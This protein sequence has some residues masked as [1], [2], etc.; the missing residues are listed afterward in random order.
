MT[1]S[2]VTG[3]V[4]VWLEAARTMAV[5]AGKILMNWF[6]GPCRAERKGVV[7]LV[8]EADRASESHILGAI[9]ERFPEHSVLAEE[10]AG[11][12]WRVLADE[13]I[14]AEAPLWIVDPLDGTTNFAHGFP[15]FC[16]SI[17]VSVKG[18]VVAGV[19]HD[20]LR[21][22]T[23]EA[24]K[25]GGA[26]LNGARVSV[27]SV[28][29]LDESLLVTG[30]AYDIRT[31]PD[32]NLDIFARFAL[33]CQ[34]VRRTGSAALDLCAVAA[35]RADGFWELRL[36]PWDTA[37]GWLIVLEAGGRVTDGQSGPFHL[38]APVIVASNGSIHEAMVDILRPS[39]SSGG[40]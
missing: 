13:G 28:R 7:D 33:R 26:R 29:S 38:T 23:F 4:S 32:T 40:G 39:S 19:V 36:K 5:D 22:E 18:D 34:G 37:A 25:G 6:G 1:V 14:G 35:G 24:V 21:G 11:T 16:V 31:N 3:D 2:S 10:S 17:G 20:P 8:T 9:R 12:E 15:W 27:S 30:F